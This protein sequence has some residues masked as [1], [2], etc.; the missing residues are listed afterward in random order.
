MPEFNSWLI[1]VIIPQA[2]YPTNR[3][4]LGVSM[5]NMMY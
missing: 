3:S 5:L 1:Y 4:V 2:N